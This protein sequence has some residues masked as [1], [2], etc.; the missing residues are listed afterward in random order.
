MEEHGY[1]INSLCTKTLVSD[2]PHVAVSKV[3]A[4]INTDY[5]HSNELHSVSCRTDEDIWTCGNKN[6]MK[7]YNLQGNL[8]KFIKTKSGNNPQ[9]IA[10]TR[11]G[12]L[13]YT[14]YND[15]TVNVVRNTQIETMIRR[16]GWIPTN[17]C[18]ASSGDLLVVM[19]SDCDKQ[20]K[21][22]RYSGSTEKQ[23][24][25]Y[26]D[27]KQSLF[28]SYGVKFI[29]EN[30]NLDICVSDY[31]AHA[32]VVVNQNGKLRFIYTGPPS[33]SKKSFI[34]YGI[35]TDSQSR[36]ITADHSSFYIHIL[37]QDG[38]FLCL[39]NNCHLDWPYGLCVDTKDNLYVV[40]SFKGKVKKIHY[41]L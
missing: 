15:R 41:N 36:I 18:R 17:F 28:S 12:D 26:N 38:Q 13:I 31:Y 2:R 39:I 21:V 4:E 9:D 25:Q 29:S 23:I 10:V 7:L 34:P 8:V 20:T 3:I 30:R 1:T 40:E 19:E 33:S 27:D 5:G 14:D 16:R 32:V 35:A 37:D 22:V 6:I 11:T 24:I